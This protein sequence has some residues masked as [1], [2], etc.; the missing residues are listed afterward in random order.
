MA[1]GNI[2]QT[3]PKLLRIEYQLTLILGYNDTGMEKS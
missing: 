3:D 2:S 1:I